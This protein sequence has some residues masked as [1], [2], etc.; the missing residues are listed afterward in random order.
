MK[1]KWRQTCGVLC[2]NEVSLHSK[3]QFYKMPV[4]PTPWMELNFTNKEMRRSQ[5]VGVH[6]EMNVWCCKKGEETYCVD[7]IKINQGM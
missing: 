5:M 3:S 7:T 6:V 4:S 1:K 2:D